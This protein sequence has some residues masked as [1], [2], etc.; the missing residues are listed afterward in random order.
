AEVGP[1]RLAAALDQ[2]TLEAPHA[3]EDTRVRPRAARAGGPSLP[4]ARA[5]PGGAP[6]RRPRRRLPRWGLP[7]RGL[8]RRLPRGRL[9][10]RWL[11]RGRLP[12]VLPQLRPLPLLRVL[13]LLLHLL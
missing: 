8:Q 7:Q 4:E 13:P 10:H 9:P 2:F 5:Q 1:L 3:S 6:R 12:P 11:P